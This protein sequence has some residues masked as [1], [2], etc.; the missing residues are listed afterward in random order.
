MLTSGEFLRMF[1]GILVNTLGFSRLGGQMLK[2]RIISLIAF[3]VLSNSAL[4]NEWAYS[5]K[6]DEFA[7]TS[8]HT[9][10]VNSHDNKGFAVV[11]CNEKEKLELYFSVGEY[12]G[13]EDSYPVRYRVDK[14][15]PESGKWGVSTKGTSSFV[16]NR[17]KVH[18]ARML[19]SG[20]QFLLEV[21]DFRGTPHKS[22]YSLAGSTESIGKVL[23]ACAIARTETIVEG[24]D[25]SVKKQI[26]M[27]GPKNTQC[28]KGML[29]SLGYSISDNS[30]SKSPDV[31][32]AL[33]KYMDDKYAVCGTDKVSMTDKIYECKQKDRFLNGVYGDAV[34][35]VKSFKEQC[36][37]LHMG[38]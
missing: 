38:D 14:N 17:D 35:V 27:W 11:K 37:S 26:S 8:T 13:S 19:M 4:G 3:T 33:Q 7:D 24:V 1:I 10:L 30:S 5:N 34:K 16:D 22:K 21:T 31:Y 36:G 20:N 25:S 12:I 6:I 2:F 29:I 32:K 28:N 9:A 18:L 15:T 23:D